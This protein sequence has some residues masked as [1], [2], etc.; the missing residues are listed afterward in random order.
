[1]KQDDQL[2]ETDPLSYSVALSRR[3]YANIETLECI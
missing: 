2:A 1:M 3:A